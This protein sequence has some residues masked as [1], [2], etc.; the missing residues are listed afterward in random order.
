M[1]NVLGVFVKAPVAGRV[2][3]RLA[4][5]LGPRQAAHL[6]RQLGHTVV[7]SC[8]GPGQYRTVVW[9]APRGSRAAVRSWLGDLAVD[10]FLPQQGADLGARLAAAFAGHFQAGAAGVTIIGSDCPG[11]A[12]GVVSDAFAALR[13]ADAVIGPT[14]DGGYYLIAL[15]KPEPGLFDDVAWST[16]EVLE[17]TLSKARKLGLKIAMLPRLRDVDTARDARALRLV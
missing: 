2:K 1:H 11:V 13:R 16:P 15:K 14:L 4:A 3:T 5:E 8:V 17:T 6:Y 7:A 9:F 12:G 10:A